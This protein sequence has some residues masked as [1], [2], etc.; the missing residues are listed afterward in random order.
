MKNTTAVFSVFYPGV[1]R[2]IPEFLDS[3]SKQTSKDFT[4]FLLNAGLFDIGRF[5]ERIDFTVRILE[6]DGHPAKLRKTGIQWII[7]EGAKAIIFADADDYFADNRIEISKKM[8]TGNDMT[9]NEIILVGE[10]LLQP[11]PMLGKALEDKAEIDKNYL[12]SGNCMGLSNSGIKVDKISNLMPEIPDDV[13]AFD[14]DFFSFCLHDGA[15]AIFTKET[16]TYYRQHDNN[17]ASPQDFSEEQIMRGVKVKRSHYRLLSR[18]YKEYV[19]FANLFEGLFFRLR[20][21]RILKEK[22]CQAVKHQRL[23]ST[24]RW[25]E[26]IKSLEELG[27]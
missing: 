9:F 3:L 17:T 12:I 5:L 19:S 21:D 14:W 26:P 10:G 6:E 20:N 4:F 15:K 23:L 25:W 18:F 13:I 8:L 1:E 2:Y 22:Y 16:E 27:L 7:S 24:G 11:V